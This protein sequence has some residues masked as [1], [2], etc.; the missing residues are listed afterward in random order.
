M[1]EHKTSTQ[2]WNR[3][4]NTVVTCTCGWTDRWPGSD[5]SAEQAGAAHEWRLNQ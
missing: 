1:T 2:Y 5:G 3:S 4:N